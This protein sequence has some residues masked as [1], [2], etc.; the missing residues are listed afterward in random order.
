M[1]RNLSG[2]SYGACDGETERFQTRE[3][4]IETYLAYFFIGNDETDAST[5]ARRAPVTPRTS[6]L[7]DTV[8][9]PNCFQHATST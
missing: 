4:I 7:D 8:T 1:A 6:P 2:F 5:L 3:V 9:R